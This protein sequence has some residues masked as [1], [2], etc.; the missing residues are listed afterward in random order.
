MTGNRRSNRALAESPGDRDENACVAKDDGVP[1]RGTEGQI[2]AWLSVRAS[3][4]RATASL[5]L[6]KTSRRHGRE[7]SGAIQRP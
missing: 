7:G 3:D 1:A 4:C 5:A 6:A 2:R